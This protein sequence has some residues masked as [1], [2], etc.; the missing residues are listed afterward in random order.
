[1]SNPVEFTLTLAARGLEEHMW[2]TLIFARIISFILFTVLLSLM[3]FILENVWFSIHIDS[4][5][6][7]NDWPNLL[8]VCL[9]P[10]NT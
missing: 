7:K 8:G 2:I 10:L 1:M 3:Y 9:F 5:F 4:W 6:L